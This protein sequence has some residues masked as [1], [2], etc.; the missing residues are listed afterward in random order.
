M[1]TYPQGTQGCSSMLGEVSLSTILR[2]GF[3]NGQGHNRTGGTQAGHIFQTMCP[4]K[5]F[6][7]SNMSTRL[8]GHKGHMSTTYASNKKR[9]HKEGNCFLVERNCREVSLVSLCT[10]LIHRL[11]ISYPQVVRS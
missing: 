10:P 6:S 3:G 8:E 11:W 4:S 2:Q 9:A 7:V 5:N 1:V